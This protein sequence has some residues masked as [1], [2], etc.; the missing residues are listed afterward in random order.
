MRSSRS[1]PRCR[2]TRS[3]MRRW[4]DVTASAAALSSA[5]VVSAGAEA[6]GQRSHL[7]SNVA[8]VPGP[9]LVP[10]RDD[11]R[12]MEGYHSAQVDVAVRPNTNESPLPPPARWREELAAA[13]ASI[14]WHRY[15]DRSAGALRAAIAAR[16]GGDRTQVFAANGS[17]EGLQTLLLTYA[18]AGRSVLTFEP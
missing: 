13:L 15:P 6:M 2:P 12:A 10:I 16:H 5:P 17:N 7:A 4:Y 18:G 9:D 3:P 1:E 11:L 14:E 8:N